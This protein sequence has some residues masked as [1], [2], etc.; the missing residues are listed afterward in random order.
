MA[1]NL[2]ITSMAP[3]SGKAVISL[4][5]MEML[6]RRIRKIGFFRPIIPEGAPD[7]NIQLIRKRYDLDIPYEAMYAYTHDDA[8]DIMARGESDDLIKGIMAKY[9]ALE[10]RCNF[11]LCEGTDYTGVSSA[12]EF[13]FNAAA[14]QQS[15][16]A[17]SAHRQRT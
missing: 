6:S 15:G 13:E 14:G 1:D 8:M 7:N 4:G 3:R 2:Y 12:F 17:H 10:Q 11:V 9:K 16:C 5:I